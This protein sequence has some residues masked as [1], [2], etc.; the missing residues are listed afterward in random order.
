MLFPIERLRAIDQQLLV[1]AAR[2]A[3]LPGNIGIAGK[4]RPSKAM[5][6]NFAGA[7]CSDSLSSLFRRQPV[8]RPRVALSSRRDSLYHFCTPC[9]SCSVHYF[10][11]YV[12]S[13]SGSMISSLMKLPSRYAVARRPWLMRRL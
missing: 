1:A 9:G 6:C 8:A 2:K 12:A 11:P 3:V 7:T 5:V 13:W 10:F 4:V